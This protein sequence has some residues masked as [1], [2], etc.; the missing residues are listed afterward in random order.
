MRQHSC[1]QSQRY[2]STNSW[3]DS[4]RRRWIGCPFLTPS[5]IGRCWLATTK[6]FRSKGVSWSITLSLPNYLTSDCPT[7][8][9]RHQYGLEALARKYDPQLEV[10]CE[11]EGSSRSKVDMVIFVNNI[12]RI[13]LEVKSPTVMEHICNIVPLHGMKL[14][15][16]PGGPLLSKVFLKVNSY[17]PITPS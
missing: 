11:R 9:Y 15:W 6:R 3:T 17:L 10:S 2:S 16:E 12:C 4:S 5:R 8:E 1:R 14:R 7:V 13:L